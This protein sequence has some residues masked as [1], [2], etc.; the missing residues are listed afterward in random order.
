LILEEQLAAC[1]KRGTDALGITL[2]PETVIVFQKYFEL[3]EENGKLVNLT[4]ITGAEDVATL[5]FLDSISLLNVYPFENA[6]VIDIGSGAGFPGLPLKIA[7]PSI[8]LTLLDS[9]G[10]RISFL[11]ALCDKIGVDAE[12]V[13]SRAEDMAQD[14]SRREKSDIAVSRAVSK[15]NI[16]C[17]LSLP[18]VR[19]GGV[20]IAMKS[21]SAEDELAEA[22]NAIDLLGARMSDCID[23]Q[24]PGT[25]IIHRAII[26]EKIAE[27]PVKYPR[28]FAKIQ[29]SPL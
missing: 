5:H 26:I 25:T 27:T 6:S 16:L 13:C 29:K 18:F 2:T 24:L 15:L 11:S 23:Y 8:E 28:R 7:N 20:F 17:E 22:Q 9:S 21:V 1:L 19:V 12:C 3:L 10:K 4:A 14:L